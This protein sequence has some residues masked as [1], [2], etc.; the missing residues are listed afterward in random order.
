MLSKSTKSRIAFSRRFGRTIYQSI[1]P[2]IVALDLHDM[3]MKN[4][5]HFKILTTL[6]KKQPYRLL[7]ET[8]VPNG[9][10]V[11]GKWTPCFKGSEN[12]DDCSGHVVVRIMDTSG[13]FH[14]IDP[15][16][17][18]YYANSWA[19]NPSPIVNAWA[20]LPFTVCSVDTTLSSISVLLGMRCV[21]SEMIT[22]DEML[23][24]Y[25]TL[26]TMSM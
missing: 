6:D 20:N 11:D 26:A 25:Q 22:K 23:L 10:I 18:Q 4:V 24:T 16:Y 13:K 2:R 1:P 12:E 8:I 5:D 15:T 21:P 9:Q 19:T 7:S 3:N 14:I 17:G